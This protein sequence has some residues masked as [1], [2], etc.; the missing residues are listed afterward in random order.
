MVTFLK[1]H[2]YLLER[3]ELDYLNESD[4]QWKNSSSIAACGVRKGSHQL[5][6]RKLDILNLRVDFWLCWVFAAAWI[7]SLVVAS[8]C[9]HAQLSPTL[10]N[11]VREA[12]VISGIQHRFSSEGLTLLL[13]ASCP[14]LS[15]PTLRPPLLQPLPHLLCFQV[16]HLL[17]WH[18]SLI[19]MS[20]SWLTLYRGLRNSLSVRG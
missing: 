17:S 3:E 10:C 5:L 16:L 15:E 7:F 18:P 8:G 12:E 9:A 11:P 14:V 19:F 4:Q 1:K 13:F 2:T 20:T 6:Q